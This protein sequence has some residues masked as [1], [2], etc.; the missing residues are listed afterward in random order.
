VADGEAG[1]FGLD[2]GD[3]DEPRRAA[4]TSLIQSARRHKQEELGRAATFAAEAVASGLDEDE[5]LGATGVRPLRERPPCVAR[6]TTRSPP[7][8]A[9]RP[10]G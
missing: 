2:D 10:S 4:A 7:V 9:R 1:F 3:V 6:S 8:V 5:V